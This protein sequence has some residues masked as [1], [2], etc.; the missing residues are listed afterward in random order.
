MTSRDIFDINL[1]ILS[2]ISNFKSFT[3]IDKKYILATSLDR[4]SP[5]R[6]L[7]LNILKMLSKQ[8]TKIQDI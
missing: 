6:D 7:N 5:I 4:A 3:R 8:G 1:Q 2:W